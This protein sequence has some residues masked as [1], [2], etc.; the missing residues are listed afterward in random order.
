MLFL[1]TLSIAA[2]IYTPLVH[3]IFLIDYFR[4][5]PGL[6]I[7]NAMGAGAKDMLVTGMLAFACIFVF[8]GI[9]FIWFWDIYNLD[10]LAS[11]TDVHVTL[12]S[13]ASAN[14]VRAFREDINSAGGVGYFPKDYEDSPRR[15]VYAALGVVFVILWG[16]LWSIVSG[17]VVDAFGSLRD[18][19]QAKTDD[20]N[21][22]CLVCSM[23]RQLADASC[24]GFHARHVSIDHNP[25]MYL[26]YVQHLAGVDQSDYN[27]FEQYVAD[28]LDGNLE[29]AS[30]LPSSDCVVLRANS[31]G[32]EDGLATLQESV[33][34]MRGE[35]DTLAGSIRNIEAILMQQFGGA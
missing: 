27:G 28:C 15:Q 5:P 17:F 25:M 32:D 34:G 20:K 21:N 31:E 4:L 35:I 11:D 6:S 22:R 14:M 8:T 26:F 18:E 1:Q 10:L 3:F 24:G 19:A 33:D 13:L 2:R 29:T 9:D 16:V 7:I 30:W 12:W 23:D